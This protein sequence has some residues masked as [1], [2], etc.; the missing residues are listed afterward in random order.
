MKKI[1]KLLVCAV[2]VTTLFSCVKENIEQP[3]DNQ[4][5]EGYEMQEFAATT[6][7]TKTTVE[8]NADGTHGATLWAKGDQLSIFWNGGKGT[9]DLDGEGGSN[10]GK[11]KGAVPQGVKATHA[12]Y[13]SSV[14]ASVD[15]NTVKVTI[16][17]EQRGTFAAGNI[18]VAEVAE[19]NALAFNN[20]NA[21][22]CVQLVSDEVTKIHVKSV[23]GHAL[24]GTV[25]V[26]FTGEGAE[27]AAAENTSSEV[28]MT[29][30]A[31]GHYYIS[32]VPGVT[33]NGGLLM[34]YYKGEEVSGTYFFDKN[35]SVV[36]NKIYN[37]GEF[38]P[39]GNYYVSVTGS[40]K[41]NGVSAENAMSV[42]K[43]TTLL[44]KST[45]DPSALAAVDGAVFHFATDFTTLIPSRVTSAPLIAMMG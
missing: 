40:G 45:T 36:A 9:A 41:K 22:L 30:G 11:F 17:A 3:Q 34:T 6:V 31:K 8:V 43:M 14:E 35:L 33:H 37:F 42:A 4:I 29:A 19:D 32:I 7:D 5:P 39:D 25:P 27:I 16:P 13:P 2:G 23:G 21:F 28:T 12:V 20:V 18:S 24:V 10:I 1:Y 38:E 44:Q 15:G 26:T